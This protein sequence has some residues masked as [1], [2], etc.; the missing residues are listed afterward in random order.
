MSDTEFTFE[1]KGLDHLANAGETAKKKILQSYSN[2][3]IKRTHERIRTQTTVEGEPF[4]PRKST[5]KSNSPRT[6]YD[7]G[8]MFRSINSTC[9]DDDCIVFSNIPY[10]RYNNEGRSFS[11]SKKQAFWMWINLYNKKGNPWAIKHIN[12]PKRHFLG[13]SD[14]DTEDMKKLAENILKQQINGNT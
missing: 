11:T 3:M 9:T 7:S 14:K 5:P 6:L 2:L 1:A 12:L 4:E 13:I 10:A 8:Q